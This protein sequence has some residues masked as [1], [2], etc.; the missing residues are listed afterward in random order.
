MPQ[1]VLLRRQCT[2]IG[3][4]LT[5][6]HRGTIANLEKR[7]SRIFFGINLFFLSLTFCNFLLVSSIFLWSSS[8]FL[9][10]ASSLKE[11]ALAMVLALRRT[12]E[13]PSL[14]RLEIV[15]LRPPSSLLLPP[16][17]DSKLDF[18][19]RSLRPTKSTFSELQK[20]RVKVPHFLTD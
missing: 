15:L 17:R 6:T 16:E 20:S 10:A 5:A 1:T 7:K 4:A 13:S 12:A 8:L 19:K 11:A 2:Q 3:N 9:L 18:M 14:W